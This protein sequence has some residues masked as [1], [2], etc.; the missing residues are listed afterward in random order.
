MKSIIASLKKVR[1]KKV[2]DDEIIDLGIAF[3][4]LEKPGDFKYAKKDKLKKAKLLSEKFTSHMVGKKDKA[5]S[6]LGKGKKS[7]KN[8]KRKKSKTEK[9]GKTS[10]KYN[11]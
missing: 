2:Q 10:T 9:H 7:P 1:R 6:I 11:K 5:K 4:N 8:K 3:S